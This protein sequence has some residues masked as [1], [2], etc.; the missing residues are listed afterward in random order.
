MPRKPTSMLRVAV[1]AAVLLGALAVAVVAVGQPSSADAGP[2]GLPHPVPISAVRYG[3]PPLR[4]LLV[5]DSLAGSLGVGLGDIA[6]AYNIRLVNAG[7]PGCSVSMDGI[8]LLTYTVNPPGTPCVL[9]QP[10]HL[11]STWQSWVDAYRPDVVLYVGRGDVINQVVRH[12]W[13]YIGRRYFNRWFLS[14]LHAAIAV[15]GSRGAKVVLMTVPV[16]R[17]N[18]VNPR[19]EDSARRAGR[20]GGLLRLAVAGHA[21]ASVYDL[22]ELLTPGLVYRSSA[23]GVPL[24]CVDGVHVTAEAGMVV[25]A[26]LYPRLWALAGAARVPGGG[27]WVAGGVPP[28]TPAWWQKLNCT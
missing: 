13:T 22:G 15:L 12:R 19:P 8:I 9:N 28:T 26:D 16:S 11:L 25:A 6:A 27:G 2:L 5:G 21:N 3:A 14:R 4:V 10:D 1:S 20:D 18:T 7:T 24:R 23:Q 17:Q